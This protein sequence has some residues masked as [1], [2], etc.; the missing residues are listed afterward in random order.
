[1]S[2][3]QKDNEIPNWAKTGH[4]KPVT[5]REMLAAGVIPF[6]ARLVAPA[7]GSLLFAQDAVAQTAPWIPIVTINLSGG[8]SAAGNWL[9]MDAG[10]QPLR[11]YGQLGAGTVPAFVTEF[12]TTRWSANSANAGM[13]AGI[14]ATAAASIPNTSFVAIPVKSNDD[15]SG[16]PLAI[17]GMLQKAGV[18]GSLIP[19]LGTRNTATGQNNAAAVLRPAAPLIVNSLQAITGSLGYAGALGNTLSA[20]QRGELARVI[21]SLSQEQAKKFMAL[22][23]G[24]QINA[25]VTTAGTKTTGL[26]A[27]G[28]AGVDPRADAQ[29]A[30][31]NTLWG[32]NANTAANNAALVQAS[33]VYNVLKGNAGAASIDLG[34]YDYHGNA[35]AQT[36]GQD[37]TAG[38]LIGR[39]MESARILNTPVFIYISTDGAV[40]SAESANAGVNWQ[41][42]H[43][44]SSALYMFAYNPLAKP[45][46]T[47]NQVGQYTQGQAADT[48]FITGGSPALAAAAVLANYLQ[49][50]NKVGMFATAAPNTIPAGNL[51]SVIKF[52]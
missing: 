47:A 34:G 41:N 7:W 11:S 49:L 46:T 23:A 6:A 3:K 27:G 16:N 12:G 19:M 26:I 44:I 30:A 15:S 17:E 10:G 25:A 22:P 32:I 14:R 2:K 29:G 36:D 28:G 5:R 35:R 50:N 45:I 43:G 31:L 1:M 42:D 37:R 48:A 18:G 13:L 51:Q 4:R 33:I 20:A 8:Y 24:A 52:A 21:D 40:S 39:I 9:P 38:V